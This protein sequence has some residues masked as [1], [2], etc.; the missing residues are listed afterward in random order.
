MIRQLRPWAYGPFQILLHA[1][2]H[3][4]LGEDFD[5]RIAIIGFD[6][7]IEVAITTYLG[8][9]PIQRGNRQYPKADVERWLNNYHTKVDF[10]FHECVVRN[11]VV[12]GKHD[13]IV[14]FHEVRNGQYHVG[15]DTV[16]QRRELDGTRAAAL[17]VFAVLFDVA[18]AEAQLDAHIAA[19]HQAPQPRT[20][21]GDRLID[22]EYGLVDLCG[23]SEYSSELLYALD[24]N[25]YHETIQRLGS[26][27]G[28]ED[29]S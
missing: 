20:A 23:Q 15:G 5:R 11:V 8:L 9:N 18:D 19:M 4:R 22:R 16:P 28:A 27:D 25:R 13:E 1:E 2:L 24:P 29:K 10:F 3:Y 7:A 6:N 12:I 21:E 14:W 26:G 17:E